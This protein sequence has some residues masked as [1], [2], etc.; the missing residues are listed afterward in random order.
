MWLAGLN[1]SP[2]WC[3]ITLLTFVEGVRPLWRTLLAALS[4]AD[5][6]NKFTFCETMHLASHLVPQPFVSAVASL[7]GGS[8]CQKFLCCLCTFP[9]RRWKASPIAAASSLLRPARLDRSYIRRTTLNF[10]SAPPPRLSLSPPPRVF[11]QGRLMKSSCKCN[12]S[13]I[14]IKQL[15]SGVGESVLF[16]EWHCAFKSPV[17]LREIHGRVWEKFPAP[18]INNRRRLQ[19]SGKLL[20]LTLKLTKSLLRV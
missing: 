11:P 10:L 9:P 12:E 3:F 4:Q 5:G 16:V 19:L 8:P 14:K 1:V 2:R 20:K 6:W 15:L 7:R 18:E 17:S 13:I